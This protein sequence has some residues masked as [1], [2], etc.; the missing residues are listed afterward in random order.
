MDEFQVTKNN[1]A[2]LP[3]FDVERF[4]PDD[5][6][7]KSIIN[8]YLPGDSKSKTPISNDASRRIQ[9]DVSQVSP[10]SFIN[11]HLPKDRNAPYDFLLKK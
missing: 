10:Y 8:L 2:I 11:E 3:E 9:I 6:E 7:K 4:A 5:D 1:R